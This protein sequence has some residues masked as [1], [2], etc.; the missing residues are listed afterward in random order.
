MKKKLTLITGPL[1][2]ICAASFAQ[3]TSTPQ[4]DNE[5]RTPITVRGCVRSERGNY[6][7]IENRTGTIYALQGV[8]TKLQRYLRKEV[9]ATGEVKPGSVKT[10]IRPEKAGSNPSDTVHGVSGV[11]LQINDIDKDIKITSKH[12]RAADQQ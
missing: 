9:E 3:Q 4:A 1:L 8:G 10:G 5:A 7:L 11:P 2:L 6:I 12:C